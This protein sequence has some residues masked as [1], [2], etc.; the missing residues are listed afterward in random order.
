MY[1][2]MGKFERVS[3]ECS[4]I[5][6]QNANIVKE[7]K[8]LTLMAYYETGAFEPAFFLIESLKVFSK[9]NKKINLAEDKLLRG[10]VKMTKML[11]KYRLG[12]SRI[13]FEKI[14]AELGK[15]NNIHNIEWLR[16]K[17]EELRVGVAIR[18]T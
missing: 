4:K 17:A 12:E 15:L 6:T 5:E 9:Q 2:N 11:L 7:I 10:F 8:I 18:N 1:W 14:T 13:P 16:K 3:E